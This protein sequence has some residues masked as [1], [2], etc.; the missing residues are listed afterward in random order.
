V[1]EESRHDAAAPQGGLLRIVRR[2]PL[3]AWVAAGIG[4]VL[5]V[6]IGVGLFATSRP[7][8][9]A[10]YHAYQRSYATLQTSVHKNL[11]CTDCHQDSRGALVQQALMVGDFY[12]GLFRRPSQPALARL[13]EPSRQA[14]MSCHTHDWAWNAKRTALVPHPAHLR[15]IDEPRNCVDCHKWTAHEEAYMSKHKAMPF[16]TVCASFGCHVGWKQKDECQSCHHSLQQSKG[17]WRQVHRQ[18]VRTFGPNGCLETC[19]TTDQCRLCHTTG[20][21]PVFSGRG[22]ATVTA[23]ESAHVKKD[24]LSKHGSFALVDQSKCLVCHVSEAECKDC[25]SKRPAFHGSPDS[26]LSKHQPLAKKNQ[27]R[28]LTCHEQKFCD[29]CHKQF[30]EMR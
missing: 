22:V 11:R 7:G 27:K 25:H 1:T 13:T 2:V 21:T 19:H 24:W 23:I 30:K 9:Y 15:T 26:W 14:C 28:C 4:V 18:T 10:R 3:W 20:K 6:V 12:R 8:F 29:D 16:S 5:I 17:D